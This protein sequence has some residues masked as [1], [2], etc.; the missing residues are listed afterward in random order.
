MGQPIHFKDNSTF[1]DGVTLLT[2]NLHSLASTDDSM[3]SSGLELSAIS[4]QRVKGQTMVKQ[5]SRINNVSCI[6][7]MPLQ[8]TGLVTYSNFMHTFYKQ[9]LFLTT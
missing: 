9:N 8:Y 7:F 1:R 5:M 2:S 6:I 3:I 4:C